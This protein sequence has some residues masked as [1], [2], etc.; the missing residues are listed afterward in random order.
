MPQYILHNVKW[1]NGNP[2]ANWIWFQHHNTQSHNANQHHGGIFTLS[3]DSAAAVL[4]S[5]ET[6]DLVFPSGYVSLVS[7]HFTYLL[8]APNNACVTSTSLGLGTRYSNGILCKV[9]LRAL[10]IYSRNQNSST[11]SAMLV[12]VWFDDQG[13]ASQT[14]PPS[15]SQIIGFHQI[16][17]NGRSEKQGYS[18][19]VIPGTTQSYRVSLANG[20]GAVPKDWVIEFSDPVMGNRWGVE[21]IQLSVVGRDCGMNGMV[22]SQHDRRFLWSGDEFM[23]S[24]AWG[25]HGACVASHPP[26]MDSVDCT[27]S[28]SV[29][30]ELDLSLVR[31]GLV[32]H[33]LLIFSERKRWNN[34]FAS[35]CV[36]ILISKGLWSHHHALKCAQQVAILKHPFAIVVLE[37]VNASQDL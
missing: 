36:F 3:P 13:V 5:D 27:A 20:N 10:K 4:S 7:Q 24:E 1:R 11:G 19:P 21:Y 14:N 9:P 22:S 12:E 37:S 6:E 29:D 15:A 35:N 17:D 28:G 34:I 26:D 2:S 25:N 31:T 23:A 18:F 16:G 32:Q 30:G 8:S 33:Q